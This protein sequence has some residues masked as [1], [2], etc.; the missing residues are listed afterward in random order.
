[1]TK[2]FEI[3]NLIAIRIGVDRHNLRCPI[4]AEAIVMNPIDCQ[5]LDHP[6]LWGIPVV[7][8]SSVPVKRVRIKCKGSAE[9]IEEELEAYLSDP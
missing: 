4:P 6:R 3:V 8:D 9:T 7:A 5:L 1:M 2:R